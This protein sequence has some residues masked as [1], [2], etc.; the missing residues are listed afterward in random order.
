MLLGD[1]CSVVETKIPFKKSGMDIFPCKSYFKSS[2][3]INFCAFK[4]MCCNL[5]HCMQLIHS[6]E[7]KV[8]KAK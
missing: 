8:E 7:V 5:F 2:C 1:I 3:F 6:M 4:Q